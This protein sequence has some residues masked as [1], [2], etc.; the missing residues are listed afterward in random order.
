MV[1]TV[2]LD[3]DALTT[4]IPALTDSFAT[5]MQEAVV[6]CMTPHNHVSGVSCNIRDQ[7]QVLGVA[8]IKWR[9]KYSDRIR[10]AFGDARNAVERAGE[11]I[12]IL[13]ILARTDYTVVERAR[14]G[15]G[16]DFWLSRRDDDE[17]FLFQRE[18]GLEAK[19]LSGARYP[20]EIVRAI[21][22]GIDQIRESRNASVPA[23]V[24][25]TEF[26]RPVIYMVQL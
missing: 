24:V 20:S 4:D 8:F 21:N 15:D 16:F 7:D 9:T 18:A 6:M 17:R 5:Q 13:T 3:L 10:R 22:D 19:G 14:I 1:D 12:A 23:W 11:G 2:V 25:A 26:S